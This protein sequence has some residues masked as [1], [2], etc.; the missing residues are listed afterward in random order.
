MGS[1]KGARVIWSHKGA[2]VILS[3]TNYSHIHYICMSWSRNEQAIQ[4]LKETV[5]IVISYKSIGIESHPISI[6][7][8]ARVN[9]SAGSCGG[10][11]TAIGT[12][13]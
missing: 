13:T 2:R 9:I 7:V 1:H 10:S 3:Y 12:K 6:R 4:F 5:R 11:T 8:G